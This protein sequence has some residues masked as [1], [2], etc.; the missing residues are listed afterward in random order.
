[1]QYTRVTTR[2]TSENLVNNLLSNRSKLVDLQTQISSGKRI[3]RASDDVL[4]GISVVSTN[5]SLGKIKN[6]LKNID[7]AQGEID[8]TDKAL[9]TAID[10]IQTS[11]EL[12]IQALNDTSGTEELALMNSQIKQ[13][14][15]NIK[16]L[17]NTK[18][19]TKFIF[20][21]LQTEP[22]PFTSPVDGEVQYNGSPYGSHER[23][24]EISEGVSVP[25]NISGDQV[26]GYYYNSDDDNDPMTPD[27]LHS[28]GIIGTLSALSKEMGSATP[29]KD[30]IRTQLENLNNDLQTVLNA[31]AQVGSISNRLEMTKS[32]LQ[33]QQ[34]NFTKIKSAAE[35]I[36]MAKAI[37]DLQF[38]QTAL[39]VSLQVSANI[40]QPSLLNYI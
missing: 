10:S 27:V 40:I 26:F 2:Y 13:I 8:A 4:A 11:K 12:T 39:Q 9:L 3:T 19:G 34:I 16:D 15:Q 14:I 21:G 25:I 30:V 6:Y 28:Q 1:M 37:S 38:Q 22:T 18:Y 36:D 7:N 31:Q 32:S 17:G 20:G 5:N 23:L 24:V 33:D 35:D 29:D